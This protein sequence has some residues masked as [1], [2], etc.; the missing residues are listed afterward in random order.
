MTTGAEFQ[1]VEANST[2]S[3]ANG[4][5]ITGAIDLGGSRLGQ[6][7]IPANFTGTAIGF[8]TSADAG[9]NYQT[10]RDISGAISITVAASTNIQIPPTML[11]C[12]RFL[13]ITTAVNQT[14]GPVSFSIASRPL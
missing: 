3:I 5:A 10:A 2:A 13:K 12:A 9:T 4:L 14:N 7:G 6:I 1:N 8:Q 11:P